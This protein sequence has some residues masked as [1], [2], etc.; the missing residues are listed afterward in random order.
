MGIDIEVN[1]RESHFNGSLK[2]ARKRAG[3][4]PFFEKLIIEID[5]FFELGQIRSP[6]HLAKEIS[7]IK[8]E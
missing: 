3:I 7:F 4:P 1:D 6:P 5:L 2:M 8:F